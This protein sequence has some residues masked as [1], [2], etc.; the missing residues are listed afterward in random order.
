MSSGGNTVCIDWATG[1]AASLAFE[2]LV[3]RGM[4]SVGFGALLPLGWVAGCCSGATFCAWS[5]L[6]RFFRPMRS[7][8]E[9]FTFF[10]LLI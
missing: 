8:P 3:G 5:F 1:V 10:T 7:A 4:I 6:V 9:S 2:R